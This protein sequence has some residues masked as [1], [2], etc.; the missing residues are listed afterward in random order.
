MNYPDPRIEYLNEKKLIGMQVT[1]SLA[2]N[3]TGKL[4]SQF[5][6]R[7]HEISHRVSEDKL[8]IQVYPPL[9]HTAF[10][11]STE[12]VKWAAVEA[13]DQTPIPDGMES[14][15]KFVKNFAKISREIC[16]EKNLFM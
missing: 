2:N 15:I 5:M 14:L 16:I 13:Q 10:D 4:W 11:P 12:F 3:L 7:L 6:P 1:M 9:Y 8:S